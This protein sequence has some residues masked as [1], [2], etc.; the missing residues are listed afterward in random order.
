MSS[1][2][3]NGVG[4]ITD[5]PSVTIAGF[6][7]TPSQASDSNPASSHSEI[8]FDVFRKLVPEADDFL[9]LLAYSLYKRHKIEW[10]ENHPQDDHKAFKK[11]AC[12]PQQLGMYRYQ[13]EQ[14]AKSF[15]DVSLD[16]LEAGMRKSIEEEGVL[17]LINDMDKRVHTEMGSIK[18]AVATGVESLK[19]KFWPAFGNHMLSGLASVIVALLIFGSFSLYSKFQESGGLEGMAREASHQLN[20]PPTVSIPAPT[21]APAQPPQG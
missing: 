2:E 10:I 18:A 4:D 14:M 3:D 16:Q 1:Y 12:T 5:Q 21:P 15:I 9:G 20:Q 6:E 11:V 7:G 8:Q 17:A 13:A 19:W